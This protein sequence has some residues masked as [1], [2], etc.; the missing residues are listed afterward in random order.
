MSF[1]KFLSY[2]FQYLFVLIIVVTPFGAQ[3]TPSIKYILL[4]LIPMLIMSPHL[5]SKLESKL[6]LNIK[7]KHRVI[8]SMILYS[9]FSSFI[10]NEDANRREIAKE[11]QDRED[12]TKN[13]KEKLD[14]IK[15]LNS[16]KKYDRALVVI[17]EYEK[18]NDDDVKKLRR[19]LNSKIRKRD[20]KKLDKLARSTSSKQPKLLL[21]TYRKLLKLDPQN[22][23]YKK[24]VA[25]YQEVV[26]KIIMEKRLADVRAKKISNQFSGWDGAHIKLERLVKENLKDPDSYEHVKSLYNDHKTYLIVELTYRAKNSFGAKVLGSVQAKV[27]I[28]SGTVLKI[29]NQK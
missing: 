5:I 15:R 12:F 19:E 21:D 8:V 27:D 14:Y 18:F 7:T 11:S 10:I 3:E 9:T 2:F 1:K 26:D 24:K 4:L 17:K 23:R 16:Q 22:K 28:N 20:I 25:H 6:K 13:K 29:I